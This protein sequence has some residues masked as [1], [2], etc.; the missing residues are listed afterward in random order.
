MKPRNPFA[1]LANKRKAGSHRKSNKALR[2]KNKSRKTEYDEI[3]N[4]SG[5]L[6]RLSGFESQCSDH[7]KVFCFRVFLYGNVA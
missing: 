5:L 2:R 1:V 4:H 3:G 7:I 6:N